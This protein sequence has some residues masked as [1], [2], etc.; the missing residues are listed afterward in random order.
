MTNKE[1][2][3][4]K[5]ADRPIGVVGKQKEYAVMILLT[6]TDEG[7]SFIY[8]KRSE[9]VKQSGDICFPGGRIE[10]GE[11]I[12]NCALRETEEE[13]GIPIEKIE[14]LGQFDSILEVNRLRIHTVVAYVDKS[15]LDSLDLSECEVAQ[16][17]TVPVNFFKEKKP[18]TFHNKIY[19][20]TKDFPYELTGISPDY[21]WR[22]GSQT[23]YIYHYM[24][25]IIWGITAE[26]S[27]WFV[28]ELL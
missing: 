28:E 18:H 7:L 4:K 10:E 26:I 27:K 21:N 8:E 2:L 5:L 17:F 20:D 9:F 24:N 13:I 1:N 12:I 19:Q 25:H 23:I 3:L 15:G 16:V 6:E 14:I 11:S 22:I